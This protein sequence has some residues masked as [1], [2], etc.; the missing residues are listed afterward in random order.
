MILIT[1][2][3][4][5]LNDADWAGTRDELAADRVLEAVTA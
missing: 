2:I 3:A 1:N 5:L 4:H